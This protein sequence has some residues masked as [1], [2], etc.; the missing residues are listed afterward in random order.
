MQ[1]RLSPLLHFSVSHTL[2]QDY[3]YCSTVFADR[4]PD[5]KNKDSPSS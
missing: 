1:Q 2:Q 4:F 3:S 5:S